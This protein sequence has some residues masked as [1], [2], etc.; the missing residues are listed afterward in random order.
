MN[1]S[2]FTNIDN[3]FDINYLISVRSDKGY[4]IN[5]IR[6]DKILVIRN[7]AIDGDVVDLKKVNEYV[8]WI[9]LNVKQFQCKDTQRLYDVPICTMCSQDLDSLEKLQN[10]KLLASKLCSHARVSSHIIKDY[11][12]PS[13]LENWLFLSEDFDEKGQKVEF[14]HKRTCKT[15]K[16]IKQIIHHHSEAYNSV[17]TN[18]MSIFG[19]L[20]S[21][22]RQGLDKLSGL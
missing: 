19:I 11:A 9:M 6:D 3:D 22:Q 21:R 18:S 1:I 14:I 15:L 20:I 8:P 7:H 5:Y 4:N 13:T 17:Q 2:E 16:T 10:I 12:C